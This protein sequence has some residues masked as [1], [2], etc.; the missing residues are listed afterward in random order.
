MER[1]REEDRLSGHLN[2][3]SPEERRSSTS[4]LSFLESLGSLEEN[5]EAGQVPVQPPGSPKAGT[6]RAMTF[7]QINESLLHLEFKD[8][9]V[10]P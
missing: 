3:S 7:G 9:K 5:I 6:V 2:M 4:S 10:D 8:F 1:P